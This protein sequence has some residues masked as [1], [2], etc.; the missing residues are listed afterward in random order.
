MG[1]SG[2]K[3]TALVYETSGLSLR[4]SSK[5]VTWH[6][7]S[8]HG[9]GGKQVARAGWHLYSG[10]LDLPCLFV[11]LRQ[12]WGKTPRPSSSKLGGHICVVR[13]A[14]A[15]MH[16]QEWRVGRLHGQGRTV[17]KAPLLCGSATLTVRWAWIGLEK[18]ELLGALDPRS[19]IASFSM[20]LA[21]TINDL[22]GLAV[23]LPAVACIRKLAT[24]V[25]YPNCAGVSRPTAAGKHGLQ[26]L[27]RGA[28]GVA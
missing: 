9:K 5:P 21:L 20:C 22:C 19:S 24:D 8:F 14:R 17:G 2:P 11:L 23:P 4:L 28:Q 13:R 10:E 25:S 27:H 7:T 26:W 12:A 15:P 6:P 3:C 16:G 1:G 18:A